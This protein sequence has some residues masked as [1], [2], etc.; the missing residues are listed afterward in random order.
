MSSEGGMVSSHAGDVEGRASSSKR[1]QR[2]LDFSI[3]ERGPRVS[4]GGEEKGSV[5][6]RSAVNSSGPR[7]TLHRSCDRGLHL[8]VSVEAVDLLHD[9]DCGLDSSDWGDS[10]LFE[11]PSDEHLEYERQGQQCLSHTGLNEPPSLRPTHH[12]SFNPIESQY[13]DFFDNLVQP[14]PAPKDYPAK[15]TSKTPTRKPKRYARKEPSR[16]CH[17]CQRRGGSIG[18]LVCGNLEKLICRKIICKL[19]FGD[20]D[21]DLKEAEAK[22]PDW[23]CSHCEGNCPEQA[24]CKV[25]EKVN[26]RRKRKSEIRTTEEGELDQSPKMIAKPIETPRTVQGPF[27][28]PTQE[29]PSTCLLV[30]GESTPQT[31]IE[32]DAGSLFCRTGDVPNED[33]TQDQQPQVRP[34]PRARHSRGAPEEWKPFPF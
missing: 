10:L 27:P 6:K 3:T 4:E 31:P 25:Y 22:G 2:N 1:Q 18:H 5:A 29:G 16:F 28:S 26:L 24:Q 23:L 33:V 7:V 32:M 30:P 11:F 21:W 20:L 19:C 34:L 8:T 12:V 9:E 17:I 15:D 14:S 13:A